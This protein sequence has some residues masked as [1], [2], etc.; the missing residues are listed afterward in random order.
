MR[1]QPKAKEKRRAKKIEYPE[2]EIPQ[3]DEDG[4]DVISIVNNK[5][6]K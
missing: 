6:Q 5:Y 3:K 2:E 1:K 4:I